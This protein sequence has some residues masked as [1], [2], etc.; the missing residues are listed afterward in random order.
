[1][2][3]RG[4]VVVVTGGASGIGCALVRALHDAGARH[5]VVA[6]LDAAGAEAVAAQVGGTGVAM[7]VARESEIQALVESVSRDIGP[8]DLFMSNAGYAT[9]GGLE[10]PNQTLDHMWQ[11]HVMAHIY[12]A[13]AVL[14]GMIERGRG[15]IMSTASA[16]G[17]LTQVGSLAY[18]VTKHAAVALA[19]W[20]AITHGHQGIAV[21][22]LCPQ[23]VDT[24]IIQNSPD[25]ELNPSAD[26]ASGDGV[27]SAEYVAEVCLEAIRDERFWVL[28]HTEVTEY[29]RRKAGDIERW[30]YGMRRFQERTFEGE[31][32]PAEWLT[33]DPRRTSGHE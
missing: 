26:V 16:A 29:V 3:I 8:I 23:A 10:T 13:R 17:L 20:I 32:L 22:V 30:I 14:P 25:A 1:M 15:Y 7:D 33:D 2:D 31:P 11:V 28:P 9:W 19:E 18:S 12:A 27:L 6:D 4:G 21:S 24:R 5:L